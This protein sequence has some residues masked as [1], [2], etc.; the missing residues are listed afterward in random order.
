LP[1]EQLL[2]HRREQ[3]WP[4]KMLLYEFCHQSAEETDPKICFREEV[5]PPQSRLR[6]RWGEHHRS[7][8][9]VKL[10]DDRFT[11]AIVSFF[12]GD[13]VQIPEG[14]LPRPPPCSGQAIRCYGWRRI[15]LTQIHDLP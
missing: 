3:V 11:R 4:Q 15:L 12:C 1:I 14:Q 6:Q 7:I 2:S 13:G 8:S 5:T 9:L 10:T